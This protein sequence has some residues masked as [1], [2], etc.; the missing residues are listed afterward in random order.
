MLSRRTL[1]VV[2]ISSFILALFAVPVVAQDSL[3]QVIVAPDNSY[4]F[5]L[6][7]GWL[8]LPGDGG[9]HI[10]ASSESAFQT[11][12][13]GEGAQPGDIVVL[14]AGPDTIAGEI[15]I[16]PG[17]DLETA[18]ATFGSDMGGDMALTFGDIEIL[19]IPDGRKAAYNQTVEGGEQP[20][21]FYLLDDGS[22][23]LIAVV[24]LAT[25]D[26]LT[27]QADLLYEIA[28][29]A[30][31]GGAEMPDVAL[32]S[33]ELVWVKPDVFENID[34]ALLVT[35]DTIFVSDGVSGIQVYSL[36]GE[37]TGTI[38][39]DE[40]LVPTS[41][42]LAENG[43]IWVADGF[44]NI[45]AQVSLDGELVM[46]FG[47]EDVFSGISPDFV[48]VGPD[49]SL[50]AN[51]SRDEGTWMQVWSPDGEFLSEFQIGTA[52]SYIWNIDMGPDGNLYVVDLGS[53][54]LVYDLAGNLI[55]E[56]FA[57]SET[58]F[59]YVP[60]FVAL[61]D[62]TFVMAAE[63]LE[64]EDEA[65]EIVHLDAEGSVIGR[66][67]AADLGLEALYNPLDFALT[68]DGDLIVTDGNM[69]GSQLFRITLTAP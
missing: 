40:L 50:Y 8:V 61:D 16:A 62:G 9:T 52:E 64:S 1:V 33:A 21:A 68:A 34:G 63:I 5:R 30:Q 2:F 36:D 59:R 12:L 35:E 54:I 66:F 3:E 38:T 19:D 37:L 23:Q 39:N 25:D 51:D 26:D 60:V 47:G 49:G 20:A 69:D 46:S 32:E 14:V 6:P 67:A 15:G 41:L 4:H 17:T 55:N 42:A 29:S 13:G 11:L 57:A 48:A 7:E 31:L 56:N 10:A 45:V 18:A 24:F 22:G 28:I 58:F 44:G 27:A 53:G 65:M 43:N